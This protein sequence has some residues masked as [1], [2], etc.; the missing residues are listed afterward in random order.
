MDS[1]LFAG[2]P[3]LLDARPLSSA[4]GAARAVFLPADAVLAAARRLDEA[5]CHLEDLSGL[6]CAEGILVNYHFDHYEH[7]ERIVLRTLVPHDDGRVPSIAAVFAGAEWHERELHDFFGVTF[8]GNPNPAPLLLA[9]DETSRPL[10]KD[11]R[12][13]RA[14]GELIDPGT[15]VFQ[16]PEFD[17]FHGEAASGA[18]ENSTQQ[19]KPQGT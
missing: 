16:A 8:E 7:N 10:R 4:A 15:I 5:G 3:L 19:T 6:D 1:D 17:L 11:D 14:L 18:T 13:R 2:L 9:E 12:S